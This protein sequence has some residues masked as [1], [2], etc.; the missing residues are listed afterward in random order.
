MKQFFKFMF[1]SMLGTLL[2]IMLLFFILIG[3]ISAM[4]SSVDTETTVRLDKKSV[5]EIVLDEPIKERTSRSPFENI[6]FT[7][8]KS[9]NQ[10]GLYD[11]IKNIRKAA[12][13]ENISGIYLNCSDVDGGLASIEE[14]R[15]ALIDFKKSEKFIIAY[16]E[17]YTQNTYYLASVADKIYLHP[18]GV[19]DYRGYLTELL[20]FK[21]SLAKLE[22]E[23]QIIRHGK[24]KSAIEPLVND[25]MSDE[26]RAQVKEFVDDLWNHTK[27][28]L[29]QSRRKSEMELQEIADS[30]KIQLA[31]DA[32]KHGFV[33]KLAYAD[34]VNQILKEQTGVSEDDKI[35]FISLK[36]YNRTP[37]KTE[38]F[39]KD[40]I[41][42]VYATGAIGGGE[43]DDE[44]IG[45]KTTAEAIR[46]A[47][48][49]KN[50]KAIVFRVNSP[51]GGSLASDVI[52][53]EISLAEKEKPV[54]VS[55]GD[56]AAS[57]GYYIS[58]AADTIVAQPNTITGSIG[59]F[60]VVFNIKNMLN[61]KLGI[62][63]DHYKTSPLSD[64]GLPTHAL[65]DAEKKV[66]Q[67]FVEDVYDVFTKKVAE[68]RK[69]T[70]ADVDS[71]GQ[72]RVWSGEDAKRLGLVDVLGSF[73]DAINIAAKMAGLEN[74]RIT[75]LP[76]QKEPF[77]E[78]LEDLNAEAK[79]MFVKTKLGD[80][81]IYYDEVKEILEWQGMQMRL[82]YDIK[83]K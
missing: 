39:T 52:W 55:M 57:G 62:T 22:I 16:A 28:G 56:V 23:P 14:I 25:R 74:Y 10:P 82:P 73:N 29:S 27:K 43:G 65:S 18:E 46:K 81:S 59:V 80:A 67:N 61:N 13:D 5:L 48:E 72:G 30:M 49:D 64:L 58:C 1:A 37:A 9:H 38:K 11:I 33:D 51:G 31:E 76:Y 70:Q 2:M 63:T 35:N 83:I 44:N 79:A 75:E 45:S 32:L 71:I 50:I 42:I 77:A 6:D 69:M 21:G 54:V 41:A 36:R 66:Y 60:G 8:L 17:F 19:V 7:T 40:K 47:R 24:F 4:V 68:G 26:N 15:N 34:E 12:D 3:M 53:R 20:F 78:L